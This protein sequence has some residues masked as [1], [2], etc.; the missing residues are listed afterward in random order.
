MTKNIS[1]RLLVGLRWWNEV[2]PD[3]SNEWIFESL[4]KT[5]ITNPTEVPPSQLI[6][7]PSA[8]HPYLD[9]NLL[10]LLVSL[11]YCLVRLPLETNFHLLMG[12]GHSLRNWTRYGCC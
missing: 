6:G 1:G 9:E 11:A 2:K 7:C 10:G 4:E 12:L 5:A 8:N 3:G